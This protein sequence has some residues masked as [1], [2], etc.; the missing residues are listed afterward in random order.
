MSTHV[1]SNPIP[2]RHRV[3]CLNCMSIIESLHTHHFVSCECGD[4][5][6]DGVPD[7]ARTLAKDFDKVFELPTDDPV[8]NKLITEKRKQN[9]RSVLCGGG[10]SKK[11]LYSIS[12]LQSK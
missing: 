3:Q 4:C 12:D 7:E 6:V 10:E 1:S 5:A 11:F 8:Q 9:A 2:N